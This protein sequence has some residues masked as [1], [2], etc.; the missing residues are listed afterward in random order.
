LP[1]LLLASDVASIQTVE[2]EHRRCV[3]RLRKGKRRHRIAMN[4]RGHVLYDQSLCRKSPRQF[5]RVVVHWRQS[6]TTILDE[7]TAGMMSKTR[8][9]WTPRREKGS[10]SRVV[11]AVDGN[12]VE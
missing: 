11:D 6:K 9:V 5:S 3:L 2:F 10:A 1:A 12:D 4:S 8:Q 7:A